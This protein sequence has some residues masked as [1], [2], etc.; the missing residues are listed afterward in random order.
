MS[1]VHLDYDFPSEDWR[2]T[3]LTLEC[4]RIVMCCN[5]YLVDKK[6]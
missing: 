1:D 6:T 5:T 2:V 3:G 4:P